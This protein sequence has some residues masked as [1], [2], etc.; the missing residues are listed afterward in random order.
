MVGAV[1]RSADREPTPATDG[2]RSALQANRGITATWWYTVTAVIFL[3]LLIVLVWIGTLADAGLPPS[4]PATL[5][6]G[7]LVWLGSTLPL[8]LGYRHRADAAARSSRWTSLWPV[9]VAA[10]V[11]SVGIALTGSWL[12]GL[13][14][15]AQSLMLLNW[16]RGVRFRAVLAVTVLLG[17]AW[18]IDAHG[19]FSDG[20]TL[21]DASGW[22]LLG[23]YSTSLPLMTVGSLWWWDVL[24]TLDSARASAARLAA[25]QE[26]LRVATDVH[27]LQGHHL[28]VIA[29]HLELTEKLLSRDPDAALQ[30]LRTARKS[31]DEA[32][33]G[34]RDL[35]LRFRAVPLSDEIANARDLL[36]AAGIATEALVGPGT[37]VSP[38]A[39]LGPVIRETTTNVLR[40][41]G[42]RRARLSLA[43][44]GDDWRYEI[45]NDVASHA[46]EAGD[47]AGLE[48]IA[49]RV[50]EAGGRLEFGQGREGFAV[51]VTIPAEQAVAR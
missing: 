30:T 21:S 38:P 12:I 31:V 8:L 47:G 5:G 26:R 46:V 41:G 13:T 48:G 4:V 2:E 15:L 24:A 3:E 27:D 6:V 33:Q 18:F 19:T 42:G 16:P 34:T 37:D 22:T 14:P 7:G 35:A 49:R 11:G 28:Q 17:C 10:V 29:L 23:F 20:G 44:V 45:T 50:A 25:T 1:T 40:H 51:T 43:R 32:R 9:I 39:E 36:V